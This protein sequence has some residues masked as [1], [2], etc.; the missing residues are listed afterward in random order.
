[1]KEKKMAAL[2]ALSRKW[3]HRLTWRQYQLV[4]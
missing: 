4:S 1:M 3:R 2:A